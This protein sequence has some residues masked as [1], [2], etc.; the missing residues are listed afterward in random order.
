MHERPYLHGRCGDRL[1]HVS[2]FLSGAT[3]G[4]YADCSLALVPAKA[5]PHMLRTFGLNSIPRSASAAGGPAR[6]S[7]ARVGRLSDAQSRDLSPWR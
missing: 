6:Q 2:S 3:R 4:A 5:T 7:L 1:R